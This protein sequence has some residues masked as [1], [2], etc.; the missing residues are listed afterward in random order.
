MSEAEEWVKN[1]YLDASALVKLVV[2]EGDC[3]PLLGFFQS[4]ANFCTTPLCLAEAVGVL[5]RKWNRNELGADQYFAAAQDLMIEVWG[6]KIELD[7]LGL[8][9]PTTLAK[10]EAS[11]R[12]YAL[13]LS[14]ALQ[15]ETIKNGKN[16]GLTG[17][18]ASVIITAD[19][20]LERA[21]SAEGIRVWNCRTN[22]HPAWTAGLAG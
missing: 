5:K 22:E 7:D 1:H 10:V 2:D 11:A 18:S 9:T 3:A 4:Q 15:L 6:G 8:F 21:A 13:D 14:D 16:A 20:G 12:Q 17:P 19:D